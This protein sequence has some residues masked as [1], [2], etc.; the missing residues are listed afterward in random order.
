[1]TF[2]NFYLQIGTFIPD[3]L[4]FTSNLVTFHFDF[5]NFHLKFSKFYLQFNNLSL[6]FYYLPLW[7]SVSFTYNLPT[8]TWK[9]VFPYVPIWPLLLG[10]GECKCPV[11]YLYFQFTNFYFEIKKFLLWNLLAFTSNLFIHFNFQVTN[12]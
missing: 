10:G 11:T 5:T 7:Y 6:R 12:F 2:S 9:I 1:M 3:L 8:F 4:I